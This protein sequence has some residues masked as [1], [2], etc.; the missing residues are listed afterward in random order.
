M[1]FMIREYKFQFAPVIIPTL[2]R[3][4]HF[5]RCLDSLNSCEGADFTDVYI[6]VD[7]P[8][9][10]SH[11]A[12]WKAINDYLDNF[13]SRFKS[14]T[15]IRRDRNYGLGKNGNSD[16]LLQELKTKYDQYI[17]SEDDNEFSPNF[18][19]YVNSNLEKYR[20]DPNVMFICGYNYPISIKNYQHDT[21][22]SYQFSAWGYGAWFAKRELV[23]YGGLDFYK[24][25]F[26]SWRTLWRIFSSEPRMINVALQLIHENR[27]AGDSTSVLYQIANKKVSIFPVLSKVRNWGLDMSGFSKVSKPELLTQEI[28]TQKEYNCGDIPMKMRSDIRKSVSRY[29][30]R[31]LVSKIAIFF[32]M[33][34]YKLFG[35]DFVYF[36]RE[37]FKK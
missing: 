37:N 9:K 3:I 8:A 14:L 16:T 12:G 32:R 6:A 15:I 36:I 2:C 10:E 7:Y 5:K 13:E 21:Y 28:D 33:V 19:L 25:C 1:I 22:V 17:F 30:D 29:F 18:L 4:N 27:A 26:K 31:S 11:V 20:N 24:N 35:W 34:I 23:M